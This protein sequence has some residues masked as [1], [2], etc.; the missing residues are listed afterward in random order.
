MSNISEKAQQSKKSVK[1]RKLQMSYGAASIKNYSMFIADPHVH[2]LINNL[3]NWLLLCLDH[4]QNNAIMYVV[5]FKMWYH[6]F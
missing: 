1:D 2:K 5:E 4:V 3:A 6:N